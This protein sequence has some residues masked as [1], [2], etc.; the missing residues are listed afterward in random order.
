[1]IIM[2]IQYKKFN[3]INKVHY[4]RQ[5]MTVQMK[6]LTIDVQRVS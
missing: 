2:I 3:V 6:Y 1:M 5:E 4:H